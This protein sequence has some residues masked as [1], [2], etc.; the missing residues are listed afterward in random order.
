M[1]TL[2]KSGIC[3]FYYSPAF[4]IRLETSGSGAI[5]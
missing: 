4:L 3:F 1:L 5:Y 2:Y